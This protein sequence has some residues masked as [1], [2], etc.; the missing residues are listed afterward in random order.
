MRH[1]I[2]HPRMDGTGHGR[3]IGWSPASTGPNPPT[4]VPSHSSNL[5]S[6]QLKLSYL[7]EARSLDLAKCEAS[8][9]PLY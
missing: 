4:A 6:K 8:V 3:P 2:L 5:P 9:L 7:D 1:S